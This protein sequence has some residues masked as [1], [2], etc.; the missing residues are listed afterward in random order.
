MVH[1]KDIIIR[2]LK[3]KEYREKHPGLYEEE[4]KQPAASQIN[5]MQSR[6]HQEYMQR[7]EQYTNKYE[8]KKTGEPFKRGLKL[9]DAFI[10]SNRRLVV[11]LALVIKHHSIDTK[12]RR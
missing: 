8:Y 4:K 7:R 11:W 2:E 9:Y 5:T 3:E 6:F 12:M 10:Y 1:D